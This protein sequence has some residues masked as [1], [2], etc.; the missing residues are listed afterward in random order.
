LVEVLTTASVA[1][2]VL[3]FPASVVL[4]CGGDRTANIQKVD[5]QQVV[6]L[7]KK[8][9]VTVVDANNQKTRTEQGVIPGALLLTSSTAY[10]PD[11]E[12][13]IVKDAMLVFYCANEKCRASTIAAERAVHAGYTNVAVLPAGIAGWKAAHQKTATPPNNS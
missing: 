6:E 10:Q 9:I 13:P 12:L 8:A 1:V 5:V 3:S 7:Q 2:V 11:N 4:A